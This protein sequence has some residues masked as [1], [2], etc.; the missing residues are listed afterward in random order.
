[1]LKNWLG[2]FDLWMSRLF[3]QFEGSHFFLGV[4]ECSRGSNS[5]FFSLPKLGPKLNLEI[6]ENVCDFGLITK[7][8]SRK[9]RGRRQKIQVPNHARALKSRNFSCSRFYV[10]V[11]ARFVSFIATDECSR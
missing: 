5:N 10:S 7:M 6:G 2:F 4:K 11:C 1:M 8:R 3:E 9:K